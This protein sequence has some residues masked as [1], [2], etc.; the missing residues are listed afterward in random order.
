MCNSQVDLN[1]DMDSNLQTGCTCLNIF[2][3]FSHIV[4]Y[5]FTS[6]PF[7]LI[8]ITA[9]QLWLHYLLQYLEAN[10]APILRRISAHHH[11]LRKE[12]SNTYTSYF[13]LQAVQLI[14]RL[15]YFTFVSL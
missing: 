1:I 14:C 8:F 15:L 9:A 11:N 5:G 10:L 7:A 12:S 13:S 4:H 2:Q 3:V 6:R